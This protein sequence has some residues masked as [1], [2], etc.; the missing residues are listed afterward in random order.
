M[1][2]RTIE[3]SECGAKHTYDHTRGKPRATCGP[4]CATD[5]RKRRARERY[6]SDPEYRDRVKAA[7]AKWQSENRVALHYRVCPVC[8]TVFVQ[9]HPDHLICK[10]DCAP[11]AEEYNYG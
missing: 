8:D 11:D 7:S 9:N 5:R 6:A 10:D 3:C 2:K 1:P 4:R